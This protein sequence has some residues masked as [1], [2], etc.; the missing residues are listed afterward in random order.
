M[1]GVG[2]AVCLFVLAANNYPG[3]T[4]QTAGAVGYSWTHNFISSLFQPRALNGAPNPARFFAIPAMLFVNVSLGFAFWGVSK[5]ASS[6]V[7]LK[8]IEISGIGAAVYGLLVASPMHDLMVSIG[9]AFSLVATI[10][11]TRM[12]F[13][14][15][16]W[17]LFGWGV[18]CL[19]LS[20]VTAGMYY[21][22]ALYGALPVLQKV[23]GGASIAWIFTVYYSVPPAT[24]GGPTVAGPKRAEARIHAD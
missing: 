21:G 16:R 8:T 1:V 23:S 12:L 7:D 13:G 6:R 15:H 10:A 19:A 5:K 18:V 3:G 9:L 2:I 4:L 14:M 11:T 24:N 22:H 17:L 20:F